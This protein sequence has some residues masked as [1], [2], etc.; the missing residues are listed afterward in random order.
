[1]ARPNLR[2]CTPETA[3]LFQTGTVITRSMC[4]RLVYSSLTTAHQLSSLLQSPYLASL[5]SGSLLHSIADGRA[6]TSE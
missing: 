4:L 2:D 1:M 5:V 6:I 3:T